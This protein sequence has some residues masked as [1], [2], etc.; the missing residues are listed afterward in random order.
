MRDVSQCCLL[1][2]CQ[3][4]LAVTSAHTHFVS[5]D[6]R[7]DN[8]FLN[9]LKFHFITKTLV[10]A[11]HKIHVE[12]IKRFSQIVAF[13]HEDPKFDQRLEQDVKLSWESPSPPQ[14]NQR[15]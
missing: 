2:Y 4:Q 6:K 13:R 14:G 15:F 5:D 1:T 9:G 12:K 11:Q 8:R 7:V 3:L 10:K